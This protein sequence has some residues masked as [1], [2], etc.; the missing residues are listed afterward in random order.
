MKRNDVLTRRPR[1]LRTA[2][3]AISAILVAALA[4]CGFVN[5]DSGGGSADT[6]T[7]LVS[8]EQKRGL[9]AVLGT[10]QQQTGITVDLQQ[11]AVNDLNTQL[12]VQLTSGTA[13]DLFR[14][15]PG[16]SSPVA[17]GVLGRSGE[18]TDLSGSG[19]AE[20]L[21]DGTRMLAAVDGKVQA[22]PTSRN[23]IV[24][25]YN[26]KLF[27]EL[28]LEPPTT[29]SEW[30]AANAKLLAAGKT[31]I[32]AGLA[33]GVAIQ[34]PVY[35]LAASLVYGPRPDID[36][37]L[38]AGSTTLAKSPEWNAVFEKLITLQRE[39][40]LSP[41][42][43]GQPEDQAFQQVAGGEAGMIVMVSAGL[44]QLTEYADG[45]A[46]TIGVFALPATDDPEQT[47]VA[48]A[49]DFLAINGASKKQDAARKLLDCLAQPA[50]VTT[51]AKTLGSLPGLDL[52]AVEVP[53]GLAPIAPWLEQQK[54]T[55]FANYVWP[56]G[57][58]QQRLLQSGQ[59]LISGKID[60]AELLGQ[61]DAE[62]AKGTP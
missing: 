8:P 48:T 32:A 45:G 52:E 3:L 23:A 12:R 57:D 34:F 37:D 6:V 54:T 56:N 13:P 26:K 55:P 21:G 16:N 25:A 35:G 7:A 29:W 4:G 19:W 60:T 20:H 47:R 1:P 2:R 36:A 44:A 11:A 42:A 62:Y 5:T 51:Y 38:A 49:P 31:P 40:Y 9:D 17:A 50:Q 28:G 30:Q 24:V 41:E 61:L 59:E 27:A 53:P 58:V 14:V 10:C 33:Q 43:L 18:L 46:E 15:S 22:F 39:K